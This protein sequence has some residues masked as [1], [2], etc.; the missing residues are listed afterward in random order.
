ME[1]K[2]V[3][4][5]ADGHVFEGKSFGAAGTVTG[6]AVF[7]TGMTGYLETLTDPSYYGQIV[8]QT[9]PL[10]GNYGVIPGDF[11]SSGIHVRGYVVR[12]WCRAPSNFRSSG[13]IDSLLKKHNIIGLW[14]VDTRALTRIIRE[15]GVMN[16][17]IIALS[18]DA[19]RDKGALAELAMLEDPAQKGELLSQIA[20]YTIEDAVESVTLS[21]RPAEERAEGGRGKR[22]ALFDYGA[23]GN[24]RR[25]LL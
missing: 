19:E 14:G 3:I 8:M 16:A 23:K 22:V 6:E 25:E 5:L 15:S 24:I 17:R 9:F 12:D 21:S 20:S 7:T 1:Q 13:D 10:I 2:A 18:G 11:E 4:V